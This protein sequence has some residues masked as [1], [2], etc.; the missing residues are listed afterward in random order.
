VVLV[1]LSKTRYPHILAHARRAIAKGWPRV[2]RI[3][4]PA[5]PGAVPR[6]LEHIANQAGL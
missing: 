6:L 2:M 1:G 5:P 4:A 3:N